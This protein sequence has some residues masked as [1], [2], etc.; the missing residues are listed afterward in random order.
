MDGRHVF[1]R[2]PALQRADQ[3]P[4]DV[5]AGAD[6]LAEPGV[7]LQHQIQADQAEG[8][9]DCLAHGATHNAALLTVGAEAGTGAG[10]AGYWAPAPGS[11]SGWPA[12]PTSARV[13]P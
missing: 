2:L 10:S 12:S 11:G 4:A 5:P 9:N 7:V 6:V 8:N 3:G 1:T 13:R